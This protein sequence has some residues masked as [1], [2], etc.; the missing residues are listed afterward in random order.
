[1]SF[2]REDLVGA[3]NEVLDQ[4]RGEDM[5]HK[6]HHAF[7]NMLIEKERRR[8]D[9]REKIKTQLMGWG[10]ITFLGG[11]AW[12]GKQAYNAWASATGHPPV[13]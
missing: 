5:E 11:L 2:T 7:I 8:Q 12:I 4:R 13:Q 6:E 1:M 3:I 9:R 10:L